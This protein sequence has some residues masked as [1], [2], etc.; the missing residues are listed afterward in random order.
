MVL[1]LV[2]SAYYVLIV[3]E[4]VFLDYSKLI[5]T[6]R[7]DHIDLLAHNLD[8]RDIAHQIGDLIDPRTVLLPQRSLV[9]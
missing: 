5:T 6:L 3:R 9:G 2:T 7:R 1:P 4:R 8:S